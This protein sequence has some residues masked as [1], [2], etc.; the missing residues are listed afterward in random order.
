MRKLI[1]VL[2]LILIALAAC[3]QQST[4]PAAKGE[5]PVRINLEPAF[6][7]GLSV[8]LVRVT[9]TRG[10]FSQTLDLPI[11]GSMAEGTFEELEI[12][13]YAI[14]VE[15]FDGPDLIA[16]GSGTGTVLPGETTTVYITLQ[17][18][19]GGL[20]VVVSWGL[21]Y[22]DSRRV[23]LVGN[24]HTYFNGGVDAHLQA[25]VDAVHPEW[26]VLVDARTV[27]GYTLEN[28]YNDQNTLDYIST[29]AWDLVV[30]Q[31]QSSRPQN[32]PDLFYQYATLL[33]GA[34]H[35]TGALTG[36]YMTWAWRNNP[37]MYVPVRDAYY[38]IS[39]YLDGLVL[40]AGVA[41]HNA[42]QDTL[43]FSLYAPDNY[44]PSIYGTYLVACTMLAGIWN[45]NPIGNS[46]RPAEIDAATATFLQTV[47]WTTVQAESRENSQPVL[48]PLVPEFKPVYGLIGYDREELAA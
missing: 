48:Q 45:V 30:L 10:D 20:E 8:S 14:D 27:G 7:H 29:G 43:S 33:N 44:H 13:T 25:L 15:V 42:N 26:N 46:Y 47:A 11:T 22:E 36:F 3:E 23:L 39:A 35:Q 6:A 41:Y 38:Y 21:P 2:F 40:P 19:P 12:G 4:D 16:T 5:M 31:E 18:V 34:I 32:D 17:F 9:I 28:H 24:S 37:E 1:L